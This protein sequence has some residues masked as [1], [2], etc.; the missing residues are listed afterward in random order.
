MC[1]YMHDVKFKNV[2]RFQSLYFH[3]MELYQLWNY[4][5]MWNDIG[6]AFN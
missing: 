6:A 2:D 3:V 1:T 4:D 5:F